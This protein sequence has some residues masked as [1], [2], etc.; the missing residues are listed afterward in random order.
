MPLV[1]SVIKPPGFA[2]VAF[3]PKNFEGMIATQGI[4]L[5][6]YRAFRCPV[7]IVDL[8]DMRRPEHDHTGCHNGFVYRESGC[9]MALFT[10]NSEQFNQTD[11]G[12]VDGSTVSATFQRYYEN[13]KE[14]VFIA[15]YD[16]FYL[17]DDAISV[18][19]WELFVSSTT[20]RQRLSFPV[21]DVQ[22]LMD[23]DGNS[24]SI[25]TDFDVKNGFICWCGDRRPRFDNETGKG[26]VCSARYTYR[27]YWVLTRLM[28]QIRFAQVPNP[29]N[30]TRPVSRMPYSGS[31]TREYSFNVL[32]QDAA[33]ASQIT[34]NRRVPSPADGSFG[35]GP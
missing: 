18:P 12:Q 2:A 24:Y 21:L 13:S 1:Q 19:F 29:V 31:L 30:G 7:G 5:R 22:D 17:D 14:D 9:I 32:E 25:G 26:V 23:A 4:K 20:D 6:H 11:V 27:P 35:A 34:T 28:H 33:T 15:P 16:R 10:G 8:N 3:D